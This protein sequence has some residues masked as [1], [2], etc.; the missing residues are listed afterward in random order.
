MGLP[1]ISTTAAHP[2]S[3]LARYW[4]V[5]LVE[6][7][8]GRG[9][10]A[11]RLAVTVPSRAGSRT[12]G[13]LFIGNGEVKCRGRANGAQASGERKYHDS[14]GPGLFV[15]FWDSDGQEPS[16]RNTLISSPTHTH[17]LAGLQLDYRPEVLYKHLPRR[18]VT[19]LRR[20]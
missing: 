9:S 17:C 3:P 19:P 13:D 4:Q 1:L 18:Y 8:P 20:Q 11:L 10:S 7:T 16:R 2:L 14:S 15:F 12:L 6:L 5:T